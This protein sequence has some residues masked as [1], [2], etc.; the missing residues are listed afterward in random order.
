LHSLDDIKEQSYS[1]TKLLKLGKEKENSWGEENETTCSD[2]GGR[3]SRQRGVMEEV[4]ESLNQQ[5]R[6]ERVKIV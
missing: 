6:E 5:L 2:I 3:K 4:N 1:D